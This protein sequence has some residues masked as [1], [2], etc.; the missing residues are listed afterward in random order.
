MEEYYGTRYTDGFMD[1]CIH[2]DVGLDAIMQFFPDGYHFAPECPPPPL[3][4]SIKEESSENLAAPSVPVLNVARLKRWT[5]RIRSHPRSDYWRHKSN[6][7][8]VAN[9]KYPTL[10]GEDLFLLF[11]NRK[12]DLGQDMLDCI[13]MVPDQM[14][15]AKIS[16][17]TGAATETATCQSSVVVGIDWPLR[18][19]LQSQFVDEDSRKQPFSSL[20]TLT[21]FSTDAQA[22]TVGEYLSQTWPEIADEILELLP[23]L[24]DPCLGRKPLRQGELVML[25][26]D[27]LGLRL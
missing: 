12:Y 9:S 11:L 20:I 26:I 16:L 6:D 2:Q 25:C 1:E 17:R 5:P 22:L 18:H 7:A 13:Q 15:R 24:L 10:T 23:A 8:L 3:P 19:F 4:S 14:K 21:G 27:K